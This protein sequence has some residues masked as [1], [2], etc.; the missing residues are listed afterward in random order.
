MINLE[1]LKQAVMDSR[2]GIT[3]TD[4]RRSDLPIIFANPAFERMT[5][6]PLDRLVGHP[7]GI[8]RPAED[9]AEDAA[10]TVLD[11]GDGCE[12]T[13]HSRRR[14]GS[15]FWNE[16][17]ISPIYEADG[18][19]TH[20][21]GIHKDVTQRVLLEREL[22]SK[23]RDLATANAELE[24]LVALDAL[25]GI[26]NRRH[27]D[28]R[29]AVLW[30][31]AARNADPIALFF[32]DIDHFKHYNDAFGHPAGDRALVQVAQ[33]LAEIF[34]RGSD[35]LARYGGEEFVV[36]ASGMAREPAARF[37]QRL[38]ERIEALELPN[39][40]AP[41]ARLTISVGHI[42]VTPKA[43]MRPAEALERADRA[44]FKAKTS[45]RGRAVGAVEVA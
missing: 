21:I 25:T 32:I 38:C 43:G 33:R 30:E 16:V 41:G 6:Y 5:G 39:P 27:F 18:T 35:V 13:F 24:K 19:L 3:I 29:L 31:F 4:A 36:L 45:G 10:R 40:E 20:Y 8:M 2:D 37:A 11:D 1:L 9:A 28:E 14:D 7:C 17:S 22:R 23:T 44:L 42:V 34:Q 15:R 12:A 26:Y